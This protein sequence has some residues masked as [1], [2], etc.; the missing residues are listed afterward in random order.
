MPSARPKTTFANL[1]PD[2][3]VYFVCKSAVYLAAPG[4]IQLKSLECHDMVNLST[5][6]S[7]T[8]ATVLLNSIQG[9]VSKQKMYHQ[10]KYFHSHSHC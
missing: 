4:M 8:K 2:V 10:S 5:Q 1:H 3:N 9:F 6:E 7:L